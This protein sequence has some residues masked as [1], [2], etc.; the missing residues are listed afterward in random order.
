MLGRELARI[1]SEFYRG[2]NSVVEPLVR[3]GVANPLLWPTGAIVLEVTG[4]NTGR[5]IRVPLVATRVGDLFVVSTY[6][7]RSEWVKNL[8][9][10]PEARY[11]LGGRPYDATAYVVTRDN[12]LPPVDDLPPRVACLAGLLKQQSQL[13]GVSFALLALRD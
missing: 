9:A 1:E 7:R 4:R 10:N 3:A 13:F 12:Q 2:L 11:W 5:A 6:R 8:A